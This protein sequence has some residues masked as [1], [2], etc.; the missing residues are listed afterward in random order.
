MG[1]VSKFNG[2]PTESHFT[3]VKRILRYLKETVNVAL[4]YQKCQTGMFIGY[5]DADW[6]NDL[7]DRHSIT[8]NL[9]LM[10]EAAVSWLSKKQPVV[11]LSTSEAEYIAL[12][13]ATQEVIWIR[14]LLCDL[15]ISLDVPTT[16]MEDNQSA[17]A[18]AYNPVQHARTK[19]IDIRYH[20]VREAIQKRLVEVK[21]CSSREMVADIL[22][23]ALSKEQFKRLREATGMDIMDISAK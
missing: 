10:S 4:K 22:T 12:S 5:S 13:T 14:R 3:A 1:V 11:A 15:G 8:G 18:I 6:A 2:K 7:D 16:L 21:Y 19:H 9:F 17:I 20:F 23:K